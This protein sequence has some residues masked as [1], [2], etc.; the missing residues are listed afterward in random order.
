MRILVTGGAGYIGSHTAKAL[1][2]GGY[3][4]VVFD[5]LSTGHEHNVRWG[6]LIHGDL[7][8]LNLLRETIRRFRVSACIHFAA[9]AYIGESMQRPRFYFKNNVANTLGLLDVLVEEGNIPVVFSSSCATYGIP[10]HVP[11]TETHLQNPVNPYGDS[12]FFV[13]RMLHWFSIAYRLPSIAL[14]YFNA[15][16]ADSGGALGEEHDPETHLIPLAIQA[17]LGAIPALSIYGCDYPT[18]D[19]TAVRDYIHVSDLA[20]AHLAALEYLMSGGESTSFNLG[21][22]HGYSVRQVIEALEIV[23]GQQVP[24]RV[25]PRRDGDPPILTADAT[26]ASHVLGWRCRYSS[27]PIILETAWRWH[28]SGI[29]K[30]RSAQ[31]SRLPSLV[32]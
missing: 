1:A 13:E 21:T 16:G 12:K 11:I 25:G 32:S 24:T 10:H 4:P 20:D 29:T 22:G 9:S 3:E 6:P 18:P 31:L 28:E 2:M 17:T 14:R 5:N 8:D 30:A 19:G 7:C 27:L 23:T 15:A 26:K